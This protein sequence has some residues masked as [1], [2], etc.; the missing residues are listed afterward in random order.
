MSAPRTVTNKQQA[1]APT[2]CPKHRPGVSGTK[3]KKV[4]EG[5][6]HWEWV[7]IADELDRLFQESIS[8]QNPI[9]LPE[10]AADAG[11]YI[12]DW[13]R[14]EWE[15]GRGP[16]RATKKPIFDHRAVA[17]RIRRRHLAHPARWGAFTGGAGAYLLYFQLMFDLRTAHAGDLEPVADAA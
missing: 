8:P 6:P 3:K 13:M 15:A 4:K 7:D 11:R 10:N 14:R 2:D 17:A 5:R 16:V 9:S 1:V 12:A